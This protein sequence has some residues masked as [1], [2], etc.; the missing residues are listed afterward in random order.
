MKLEV[1]IGM[2]ASGKSTYA[3]RRAD[4][5]AL[6]I[7]HDDLTEMLHVRYRYEPGLRE[8]YKQIMRFMAHTAF[9]EQR[10]AI[11][12]RTHLTREARA[13]WVNAA[14]EWN[15]DEHCRASGPVEVM[16]ITFPIAHPAAHADR[17]YLT[18]SRGRPHKEWMNV[19]M[20]HKKQATEEPLD[21]KAEGFHSWVHID[22]FEL[23]SAD[24]QTPQP[25][26][27]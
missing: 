25:V 5:G 19:A 23:A 26:R 4:E 15:S 2:V 14:R 20:H 6:V 22:K 10:D 27:S 13:F 11:I 9:R 1:L 8:C 24:D 17:R 21:W 18:D 7:C 12:D 3:R 16:A